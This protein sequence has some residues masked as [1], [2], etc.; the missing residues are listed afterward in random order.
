[1]YSLPHLE[2]SEKESS[3]FEEPLVS[4]MMSASSLVA[5]A[6]NAPLPYVISSSA[7]R[8]NTGAEDGANTL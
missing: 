5:D 2:R 6:A 1:M 3:N 4:R 8:R 7:P